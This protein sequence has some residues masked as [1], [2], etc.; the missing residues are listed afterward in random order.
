M[1]K[2]QVR[3][4][5]LLE[6]LRLKI[7]NNGMPVV[8]PDKRFRPVFRKMLEWDEEQLKMEVAKLVVH[9]SSLS[10]RE[11][12]FCA[13]LAQFMGDRQRQLAERAKRMKKDGGKDGDVETTPKEMG[14]DSS[15]EQLAQGALPDPAVDNGEGGDKRVVVGEGT[16]E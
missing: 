14:G 15:E 3:E 12:A 6:G 7:I 10:T 5:D 2:E 13:L 11:R 8:N 1:V 16:P 9:T 4:N